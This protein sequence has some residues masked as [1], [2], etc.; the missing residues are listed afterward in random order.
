MTQDNQLSF[1]L[2]SVSRKQVTAAFDGD[3]L[4]SDTSVE[5]GNA[6]LASGDRSPRTVGDLAAATRTATTSIG[7]GSIPALKL[8][9]A[10][11]LARHARGARGS[12]DL[13]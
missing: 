12:Q 2:P 3:R 1:R 7:Y 9:A 8:E 11:S 4:P 10:R 6:R 5:G 13:T